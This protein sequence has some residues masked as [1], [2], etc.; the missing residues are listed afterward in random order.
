MLGSL[1]VRLPSTMNTNIEDNSNHCDGSDVVKQ[2]TSTRFEVSQRASG[3]GGSDESLP[4]PPPCMQEPTGGRLAVIQLCAWL[5][6]FGV[7]EF[8]GVGRRRTTLVA[9]EV[10]HTH[11]HARTEKRGQA[12]GL[13]HAK[14]GPKQRTRCRR[15]M[16][17]ESLP[18][19]NERRWGCDQ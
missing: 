8:A 2:W 13:W 5:V 12:N 3:K 7:I 19:S 18:F 17:D 1:G 6:P 4:A 14:G 16:G 15:Q 11:T 9:R 10:H